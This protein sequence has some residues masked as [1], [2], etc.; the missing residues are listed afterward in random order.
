MQWRGRK[1]AFI[2]ACL[3][4]VLGWITAYTAESAAAL[5]V[6][7]SFHGLGT[8]SVIVTSYLIIC[9]MISPEYRHAY[10]QMYA[11]LQTFAMAMNGLMTQ[12]V[13][14][15]TISVIMCAPMLIAIPIAF[16]WPESPY[17][18]AINGEFDKC[19]ETFSWLGG[20]ADISKNE[21]KG[22][23][24]S[25][26]GN[27]YKE[28]SKMSCK[29]ILSTITRRDFYLPSLHMFL[30]QYL[31]YWSG[32]YVILIYSVELIQRSTQNKNAAFFGG[33]IT[34]LSLC[35]GIVTGIVLNRLF[36]KKTIL[37]W[38]TSIGVV[39]MLCA[40]L[41]TFLQS[42][43]VLPKSSSLCLYCLILFMIA[44]GVIVPI[45][46]NIAIEIMPLKHRSIGGAL[47]VACS[48]VLH[49]TSLKISP[50]LFLYIDLWATFICYTLNS[51]CCGLFIWKFVPE[52]KNKS[53]QEIEDFYMYG[54]YK[55]RH[56]MD[57]YFEDLDQGEEMLAITKGKN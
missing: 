21:L 24:N 49:Y 9:E 37:L 17:W 40:S 1:I 4:T 14:W 53:L 8:N 34:N 54:G 27:I 6:A 43:D 52:T 7:E 26:K 25:Q 46:F 50:Y 30:L 32:S 41:V 39:S 5:L 12:Y 47:I 42:V 2:A 48:C 33:F 45:A 28:Q 51:L 35:F 19:E 13:N 10:M 44:N 11:V 3:V 18:L 16:M 29:R 20:E 15:R 22:H 23:L 56:V 55:R 36:N 57:E 38:F 31:F